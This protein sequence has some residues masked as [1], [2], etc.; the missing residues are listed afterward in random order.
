MKTTNNMPARTN[1]F[2]TRFIRPGAI[3]YRFPPGFSPDDL[4]RQLS[5]SAWRGQII[6]AHGSGK[7]TLIA[8]LIEPIE[9]AGRRVLLFALRNGQRSLPRDWVRQAR[10][11]N[12]TAGLPRIASSTGGQAAGGTGHVCPVRLLIIVDG[13]EQLSFWSRLR[14]KLVCRQRAWGLLVTAHR[15]V[16]FPSL[17][18]T[19]PSL[20]VAQAVVEMLMSAGESSLSPEA[21]AKTFADCQGNLRETLFVL[22]DR[23][24]IR[25][26]GE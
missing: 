19:R 10:V 21:V 7:S 5:E 4:V 1:P 17:L 18:R 8:S 26:K 20:E 22:Y 3:A 9:R 13:Y 2:S 14:L 11:S 23:Y 12:A 25:R 6:G 24:E 15:D 16:G